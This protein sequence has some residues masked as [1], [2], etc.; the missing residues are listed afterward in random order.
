M[1]IAM[2]CVSCTSDSHP[3]ASQ[4]TNAAKSHVRLDSDIRTCVLIGSFVR[5]FHLPQALVI[6]SRGTDVASQ[7]ESAMKK[8]FKSP[9]APKRSSYLTSKEFPMSRFTG[10]DALPIERP[11]WLMVNRRGLVAFHL[12]PHPG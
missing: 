4:L 5:P 7:S 9:Q 12:V 2:L 1:D 11:D 8:N 6:I 3:C 10:K